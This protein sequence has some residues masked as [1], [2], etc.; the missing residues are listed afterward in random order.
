MWRWRVE[1][2]APLPGH[3]LA[4]LAAPRLFYSLLSLL[5]SLRRQPP[6]FCSSVAFL[7]LCVLLCVLCASVVTAHYSLRSLRRLPPRF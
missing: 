7:L 1:G 4:A 5:Y 2:T 6:R 3:S